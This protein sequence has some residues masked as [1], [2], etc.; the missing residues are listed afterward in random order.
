MIVSWQWVQE[1]VKRSN[2]L[3]VMWLV[4][5]IIRMLKVCCNRVINWEEERISSISCCLF[6]TFLSRIDSTVLKWRQLFVKVL[7]RMIDS[8]KEWKE[9]NLW[10]ETFH[11]YRISLHSS[12]TFTNRTYILISESTLYLLQQ[13]SPSKLTQ[14]LPPLPPCV[15]IWALSMNCRSSTS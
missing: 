7:M 9:E 6:A 2:G 8:E 11:D 10:L 14:P 1:E 15:S 13:F 12:L 5:E 4:A 3:L